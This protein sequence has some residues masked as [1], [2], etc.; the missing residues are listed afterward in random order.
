MKRRDAFTLIELLVVIAIIA[1]LAAIL[2]PVF[3]RA[4]E[5]ARRASCMSNLKQIGL[6]FLQYTQDY[7]EHMPLSSATTYPAVTFK[8]PNGTSGSTEPWYLMIYP[9]VKSTQLFN[10]PSADSS[11]HNIGGYSLVNMNY[12]YNFQAPHP[13]FLVVTASCGYVWDCGVNLSGANLASVEDAAGT[14]EVTEGSSGLVDFGTYGTV[15]R[16]PTETELEGSGLCGNV[17]PITYQS[18]SCLRAPHMSTMNT[19]FV[20]GHVKAMPWKSIAG[21]DHDPSV[22]RYWTTASSPF[23]NNSYGNQARALYPGF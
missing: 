1:I 7:D 19:L 10:C 12:A 3:A 6:G 5:N 22:V 14:I 21:S 8:F 11:L 15:Q 18:A 4:R 9:Y 2:F 13:G 17:S 23:M 20:D 16:M